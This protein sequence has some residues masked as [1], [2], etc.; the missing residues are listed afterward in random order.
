MLNINNLDTRTKAVFL[1]AVAAEKA[2]DEDPTDVNLAK[3]EALTDALA[4]MEG[5]DA[6]FWMK[7][8]YEYLDD[9]RAKEFFERIGVPPKG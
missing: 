1:R 6:Q 4:G 9:Q 3:A 8:V 7:E 5:Q 2:F